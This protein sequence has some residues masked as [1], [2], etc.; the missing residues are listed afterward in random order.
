MKALGKT[1]KRADKDVIPKNIQELLD[2]YAQIWTDPHY[3]A[4][5]ILKVSESIRLSVIRTPAFLRV[6]QEKQVRGKEHLAL[7]YGLTPYL[8]WREVASMVDAVYPIVT[9]HLD[10][11]RGSIAELVKQPQDERGIETQLDDLADN[12]ADKLYGKIAEIT[13][14]YMEQ[15]RVARVWASRLRLN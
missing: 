12:F 15:R 13:S 2:E 14:Q 10:K 9:E 3:L 7:G 1:L 6:A 11:V 4:G 5:M 8:L